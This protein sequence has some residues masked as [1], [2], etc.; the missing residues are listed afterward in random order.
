MAWSKGQS[1]NPRGRAA[2]KPELAPTLRRLLREDGAKERIARA[3]IEKAGNGDIDAIKVLLERVDGKVP[4]PV[5]V[6]G[7][8]AP[9]RI[10]VV[11]ADETVQP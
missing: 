8:E 2:L 10:E 4:N 3:L 1:G 7:G 6:S 11:F 5:E 9:I